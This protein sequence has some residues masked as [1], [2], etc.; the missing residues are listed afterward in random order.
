[1][2]VGKAPPEI[3]V[4]TG[5][6]NFGPSI[7]ITSAP[8]SAKNLAPYGPDHT[9]VISTTLMPLRGRFKGCFF[10]GTEFKDNFLERISWLCSPILG[11]GKWLPLFPSKIIGPDGDG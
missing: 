6:G 4:L 11:D 7:L 1:M 5:S 8:M 9:C 2:I 3:P 10:S